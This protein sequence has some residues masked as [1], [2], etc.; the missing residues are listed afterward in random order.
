MMTCRALRADPSGV[1]H[2][3]IL[4]VTQQ[5]LGLPGNHR[6]RVV[7]LVPGPGGQFAQCGQLSHLQALRLALGQFFENAVQR[8]GL[9]LQ[10][11]MPRLVAR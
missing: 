2:E 5:I 11:A 8:V 1:A 6:Q 4:F 3:P 9:A 7:D 10:V